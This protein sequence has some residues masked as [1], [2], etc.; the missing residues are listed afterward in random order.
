MIKLLKLASYGSHA[1]CGY[2]VVEPI[3]IFM[4]HL[5]MNLMET[6]DAM[7]CSANEV[8]LNNL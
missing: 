4:H 6:L 5:L 7:Y 8:V 1:K 3:G 2:T